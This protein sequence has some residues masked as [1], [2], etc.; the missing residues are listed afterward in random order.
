MSR[1]IGWLVSIVSGLILWSIAA[2]SAAGRE[3]WDVGAYWSV[4]L[5]AAY[6]LCAILGYAFPERTWRWPLAVMLVQMPVMTLVSREIG[7]LAPLGAIFLLI[8]SLP[9]MALAAIGSALRRWAEA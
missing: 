6:L 4:F 8:Q 7:N 1:R 5:P 9:G 2:I 3:I